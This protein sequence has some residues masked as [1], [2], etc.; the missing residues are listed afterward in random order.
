MMAPTRTT[1]LIQ[2]SGM[3]AGENGELLERVDHRS[4]VAHHGVPGHQAGEADG[5]G[6]IERGADNQRGDDADGQVALRV[7]ALLG[8]GGDGVEADVSKKYNRPAGEHAAPAVGHERMPV[9]GMNEADD[10]EDEDEN[11]DELDAHHD[12]VGAG[13][14]ANSADQDHREDENDEEGGDVEANVPAGMVKPVAGQ[15]LEAFR[16][17]SGGYPLGRGMQA[18]P[19]QQVHHVGSKAHADGHVGAGVLENQ[20]QPMIQ[21]ISSPMVA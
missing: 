16:Q 13:R 8:G 9:A 7:A 6:H 21:A 10:G 17:I 14:L 1:S 3:A 4:G 5:H 20:S 12:V 18:E 2:W 19:V 15:I 11:G